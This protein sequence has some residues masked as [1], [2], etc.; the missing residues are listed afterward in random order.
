MK[1]KV[2]SP[3]IQVLLH[4]VVTRTAP[5]AAAPSGNS[6]P[7]SYDSPS[8]VK[9]LTNWLGEG[10]TIHV[11]KSVRDPCGAFSVTFVDELMGGLTDSIAYM[12]EPMDMLE[13]RF[14]G[15][16]W[17]YSGQKLPIMMFGFVSKVTRSQS[18]GADGKPRRAVTVIGHD[19]GKILQLIQ[20]FNMPC[21][22][23]ATN[24][25]SSFPFFAKYGME[26]NIQ[27]S[28]DFIQQVL[29]E[30]V[31]PYIQ[32]LQSAGATSGSALNTITADVQ[33]PDA[34]MTV[35]LGAVNNT[36]V[37]ELLHTYLDIG[38]FN[39]FFIEDRDAGSWGDE[40]PYMVYRPRPC[41]DVMNSNAPI[42]TIQSSDTSGV[43]AGSSLFP[44]ANCVTIRT[45]SVI[46]ITAER[47][48]DEVG[49]F[50]WVDAP[51]FNLNYDDLVKMY[52]T[53]AAQQG[54]VPFYITNY[55]NCN[56]LIYGLRKM[57]VA[58]QMGDASETNSGNGTPKGQP[59]YDNQGFFQTWIDGRRNALIAINKDNVV[60]ESGS[61]HLRGNEKIKAGSYV[62]IDY[63]NGL[64]SLHYAHSVTHTFEPFGAFFTEV[65]YE[66]GTNFIDRLVASQSGATPYIAEM[67]LDNDDSLGI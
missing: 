14:A 62:Q 18:M 20:V 19:Y 36:N 32:G 39:E 4:K 47:S 2:R 33:V 9:D 10:S 49:N 57:E 63:G 55:E 41:L 25:I 29:A 16:S 65:E 44:T 28:T 27:T 15:D 12:F 67:M 50:Y 23:E 58:T 11:Q 40:G 52:A 42:Q 35:Q 61:L 17:K 56:P 53:Y 30:V 54:A 31:N 26:K 51:R 5:N 22:P 37:Q 8:N 21:T 66:R 64:Q 6:A 3:K 45:D 46:S 48:D 60:Y 59:R 13:I 7:A 24:L 1:V 34:L 43:Y 38:P